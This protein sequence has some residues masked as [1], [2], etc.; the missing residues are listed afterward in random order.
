MTD[1]SPS[2][3]SDPS[4]SQKDRH[5]RFIVSE[6]EEEVE[7]VEEEDDQSDEDFVSLP[8]EDGSQEEQD[9][10]SMPESITIRLNFRRGQ[11][12]SES[13][14]NTKLRRIKSWPPQTF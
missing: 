6:D 11:P 13:E 7:E 10:E 9:V 4:S 1:P 2:T 12:S 14:N 3:T 5:K 8:G